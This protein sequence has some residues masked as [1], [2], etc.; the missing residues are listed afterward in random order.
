MSTNATRKRPRTDGAD[1]SAA[2]PAGNGPQIA[3]GGAGGEVEGLTRDEEFWLEDGT[4]IL[5]ARNVEF[6]IYGG[7]LANHSPVFKDLFARPQSS[8]PVSMHGD[9]ILQCPVVHLSDSP[10]DLRHILRAYV[11]TGGQGPNATLYDEKKPSFSVISACIRLGHKYQLTASYE[12]SL[13]YLKS[14]YTHDFRVWDG[15]DNWQ[16]EGWGSLEAIGVVNLA[17]L[18]GEP[19]LLPT[20]LMTCALLDHDLVDGF[21]REDGTQENLTLQD[22]GLCLK[23]KSSIRK[24]SIRIVLATLAAPPSP[25]CTEGPICNRAMRKM[26]TRLHNFTNALVDGDPFASL[27][28]YVKDG[29]FKMCNH[30]QKA[31]QDRH[32]DSRQALWDILPQLLQIEVP[33]WGQPGQLRND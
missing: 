19:S 1:S 9:Q 10:Q 28:E 12:Q 27:E 15:I 7:L 25:Q 8:R 16:P 4:V 30:C 13:K 6:R 22:L 2:E 18:I 31:L 3:N 17:R 21:T 5:I 29:V 24:A 20:A 11:P 14:H 32:W 23:A 33:G 26:S